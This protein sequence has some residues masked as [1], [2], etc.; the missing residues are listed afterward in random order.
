M[1]GLNVEI[2][3]FGHGNTPGDFGFFVEFIP[4]DNAWSLL[5]HFLS[6]LRPPGI[7][8]LN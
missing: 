5:I 1:D 2:C 3:K 6:G 8:Y 4:G 7:F